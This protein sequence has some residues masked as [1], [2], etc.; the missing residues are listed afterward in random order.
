MGIVCCTFVSRGLAA[1]PVDLS[2]PVHP[3]R[4]EP[5]AR[6]LWAQ[7]VTP[8]Q[9]LIRLAPPIEIKHPGGTLF[10]APPPI[11]RHAALVLTR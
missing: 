9:K 3:D 8:S 7:V 1:A 2:F 4:R 10:V 11:R 6:E 5:L